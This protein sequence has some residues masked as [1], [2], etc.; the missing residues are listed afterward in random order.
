MAVPDSDLSLFHMNI[1]SLSLHVDEL[2]SLFSCLNV[3]F[4]VIGL[5]ET[6]ATVGSQNKTNLELPGYKFH[7]TPSHSSAGGLG[8][9][10]K[11]NLI[12]NKRDDLCIN[13]EDFETVWIEIENPKAKNILCCCAYRHPNSD[14]SKFNDYFQM[15]LSR[16][17]KLISDSLNM[18]LKVSSS[19]RAQF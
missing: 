19:E 7:E 16:E 14:I 4:Q 6:K 12:A 9:Y 1:R 15:T 18:R 2:Y 17:V 3:N 11:S 10:V 13:D 8:I 5:S